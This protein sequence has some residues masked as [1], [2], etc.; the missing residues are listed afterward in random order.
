MGSSI[1]NNS[2]ISL[3]LAVWLAVDPYTNGADRPE[4][5][6]RNLISVT[7]LLKP[8]RQTVLSSR[9]DPEDA[10][11]DIMS[12]VKSRIGH[13]I[14]DSIEKAWTDDPKAREQ[15]LVA[16]GIPSKVAQ[17]LAI[18]PEVPADLSLYMEQRHFREVDVDGFKV[19]V[20]GQFDMV[21]N[22][23]NN[24]IKVTST[25]TYTSG[26][27][28][29]DYSLQGSCYRWLAP[30]II[31]SDT[32]MIQH[33]FTDWIASR[34]RATEEYPSSPVLDTPY[35]LMP[36][37]ETEAWI[38]S[39]IREVIKNQN[40][41]EQDVVRCTDK[42]LWRT[43]PSYKYYT[44]PDKA[45]QGRRA[46]KVFS[47]SAAAHRHRAE[48]GKGTVLTI[49]GQVKACGYCPAFTLCSQKDMYEL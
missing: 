25:F 14:H 47:T 6:G 3:P 24:D 41:P 45:A 43:Q 21:L 9:L 27:K 49:P 38:K 19:V 23:Q 35:E 13:A 11:V 48:K 39:R 2:G 15:A 29:E 7:S 36:L 44:D 28:D 8:V 10:P 4:Y 16:L 34:A 17:K 26:N 31:T 42:E 22:G 5:Q 20:S 18:N 1:T 33:I 40:L 30:D 32:M 46:S 37:D 12:R